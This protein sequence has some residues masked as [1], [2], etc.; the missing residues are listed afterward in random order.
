MRNLSF[1]LHFP[2]SSEVGKAGVEAIIE[3]IILP[4]EVSSGHCS[5]SNTLLDTLT[6]R[7]MGED[8]NDSAWHW[9]HLNCSIDVSLKSRAQR[10][11][12]TSA[13]TLTSLSDIKG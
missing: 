5:P 12:E 1:V 7:Q 9:P 8:L 4:F 10:L 6:S 11:T 3:N 13:C 2:P